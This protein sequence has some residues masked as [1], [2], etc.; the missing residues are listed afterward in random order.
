MAEV[1]LA[2]GLPI[3]DVNQALTRAT[4]IGCLRLAKLFV[5]YGASVAM[6]NVPQQ[7]A[8]GYGIRDCA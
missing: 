3:V 4:Q 5:P 8:K 6:H 1:L 2:A 7:R